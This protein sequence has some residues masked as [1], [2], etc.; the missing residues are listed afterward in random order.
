MVDKSSTDTMKS[1]R[2]I[3]PCGATDPT[4]K[5]S[6]FLI[7][8]II[9]GVHGKLSLRG[10]Y[11]INIGSKMT[12]TGIRSGALSTRFLLFLQRQRSGTNHWSLCVLARWQGN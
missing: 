10:D 8:M 12:C 3:R 4:R 11:F 6:P 7:L 9:G 2:S 1:N 5:T